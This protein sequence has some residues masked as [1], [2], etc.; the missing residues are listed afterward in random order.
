ME[1][2]RSYSSDGIQFAQR[3]GDM[4]SLKWDSINFERRL[5]LEQS[6]KRAECI[7]LSTSI[8]LDARTTA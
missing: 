1:K 3:I 8:C 6:K 4:H 5:D 7:F 2:Y